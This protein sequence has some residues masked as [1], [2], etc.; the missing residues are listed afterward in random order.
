MKSGAGCGVIRPYGYRAVRR[1]SA[2]SRESSAPRSRRNGVAR[3]TSRIADHSPVAR[4]QISS[5]CGSRASGIYSCRSALLCAHRAHTFS[6]ARGSPSHIFTH[7]A[8]PRTS[9]TVW[10]LSTPQTFLTSQLRHALQQLTRS[11]QS[12]ASL[13]AH[14][15]TSPLCPRPLGL[16]AHTS[17]CDASSWRAQP[18]ASA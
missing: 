16:S 10:R 9:S 13:S 2:E 6:R 1:V 7:I 3:F 5:P 12:S 11:Q 4:P 14:T 18:N 17:T 8:P 15:S